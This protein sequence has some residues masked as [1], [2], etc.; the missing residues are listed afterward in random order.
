LTEIYLCHASSC[1][2]I[3]DLGTPRQAQWAGPLA[4]CDLVFLQVC[5]I[6]GR[7]RSWRLR[8]GVHASAGSLR[9]RLL[10]D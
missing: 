9:A 1:Q 10:I 5:V 8:A 6:C 2:A 7:L 3:E 4:A